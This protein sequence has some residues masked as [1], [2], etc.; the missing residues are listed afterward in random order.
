M[1]VLSAQRSTPKMPP[2]GV[3]PD[4]VPL[5]VAAAVKIWAGGMVCTNASGYAQPASTAGGVVCWG[6][7]EPAQNA[8][9]ALAADN[10]SG[11]NGAI[12]LQVRQGC[13]KWASGTSADLISVTNAGVDCYVID[14][15][16]VG[17]TD[18]GGTRVRAGKI[19]QVDSDG[20]VWV[21]QGAF[22]RDLANVNGGGAAAGSVISIPVT[23]A[24]LANGALFS[25]TPGF[26]CR[27]KSIAFIDTVAGTGAGASVVI[28]PSI[29]AVNLTG[30][31][32]TPTLASTALWS[33][34]AATAITG[35]NSLAAS[36]AAGTLLFTGSATTVFTGGSGAIVITLA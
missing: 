7:A 28:T 2:E 10:T 32:L 35:A 16:T 8:A 5:P 4:V 36:G 24:S 15:F 20:G 3:I 30:G 21:L 12:T 13:F 14:D 33:T 18:G 22:V 23:L 31:V 34:T 11:S 9:G 26:A 25:V 6:R 29:N 1:A 27:V 17:L 19:I